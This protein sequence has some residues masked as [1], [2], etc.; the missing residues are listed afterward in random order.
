MSQAV[1]SPP[2]RSLHPSTR[3]GRTT[4]RVADAGRSV[5][6]YQ[7]VLGLRGAGDVGG[8]PAL[9]PA[10]VPL[11]VLKETPGARQ[12]RRASGL[13]HFAV[14][15]PS[16]PALGKALRRLVSAGVEIGAADHLVSEALY[17][18]DPDGNGIEIYRDRPRSE[19][20]WK[21]GK[22]E[23]ATDPLDL[24]EL[25]RE[26][27]RGEGDADSVPDGT[28]MGHIHLQCSDVDEAVRF[29]H[30]I[31]GFDIT[32]AW[33]GAAF[34]SA[35]G[36]HHHLGLNSWASRGAPAASEGSAGLESFVIEVPSE[37]ELSAVRGRLEEAGLKPTA[38][39]GVLRVR[40]PWRIGVELSV[41]PAAAGPE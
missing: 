41:G 25:L 16:R 29:Y 4:L 28:R 30:G 26:A 13:Y 35:G 34:L 39:P 31:L 15:L 24:E 20:K 10:G 9:G 33:H 14:L 21:E 32:A 17:L 36:Y 19:W 7:K 5:G 11:I 38:A 1:T 6:F 3:M 40:D 22:V 18:S 8:L 12:E 23:M 2:T 37:K 27:D